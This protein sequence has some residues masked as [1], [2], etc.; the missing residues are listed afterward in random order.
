MSESAGKPLA[1]DDL[2]ALNHE[3]S[4]MV[5][6]GVPIEAG[7]RELGGDM[8]GALGSIADGLAFRMQSGMNLSEALGAEG[9]RVPHLYRAIVDVG[10]RSGRLPEALESMASHLARLNEIKRRAG[11]TLIYPSVVCWMAYSLFL[12]FL[13]TVLQRFQDTFEVFQ[14]DVGAVVRTLD[15]LNRTM[16]W[17]A[18]IPPVIY[19]LLCWKWRRSRDVNWLSS[20]RLPFAFR[21][22]P[23]V[24]R[25][26]DLY[27]TASFTD[28]LGT[29]TGHGVPL[30]EALLLAADASGDRQLQVAARELARAVTAGKRPDAVPPTTTNVRWPPYLRWVLLEA[31]GRDLSEQLK[32]A[33][34]LYQRRAVEQWRWIQVTFPLF[35]GAGLGGAVTLTYALIMLAPFLRL[36][37]MLS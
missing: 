29:L 4:A 9:A 36:L 21:I 5:R 22:V 7:L 3:I 17:W 2:I 33:A 16:L 1:I 37:Q 20:R 27:R 11:I 19:I 34:T 15:T 30:D 31:H 8:D 32:S 25:L 35:A 14:F 26:I 12:V 18:W 10:I 28:L 6:A 24:R 13:A 23:G